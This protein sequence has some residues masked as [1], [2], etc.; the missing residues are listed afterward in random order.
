M[1]SDIILKK[2]KN[3]M[4]QIFEVAMLI[5]FGLSWPISV[6]KGIKSKSTNG[7]SLVFTLV[8]I[9]GY[10]CGLAS[11]ILS[12][13]ITYVMW[14]YLFNLVVVSIDMVVWIINHNREV[15][16]IKKTNNAELETSLNKIS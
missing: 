11:K 6:I 5:C 16:Q 2:E 12:G 8:I 3:I 10:I 14:L 4:A 9:L 1:S 15:K 13:N 7:K